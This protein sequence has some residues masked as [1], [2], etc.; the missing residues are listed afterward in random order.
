MPPALRGDIGIRFD[1]YR[2]NDRLVEGVE[3]VGRRQ[4]VDNQLTL[5]AEF[6][7]V[8]G[9]SLF[10]ELPRFANTIHF[11]EANVM[12]FDPINDGGTMVDTIALEDERTLTGAGFGGTWI[13]LSG[14]PFHEALFARRG[15]RSS[16]RF[17]A[18]YRFADR[19]SFWT[20]TDGERGGGVGANAFKLT[21]SFSTTHK[22]SQPYLRATLLRAGRQTVEV[23]DEAGELRIQ[24][25]IIRPASRVDLRT[26]TEL[27]VYRDDA[28]GSELNLDFSASFGYRSPQT[29]PSGLLLPSILDASR[30]VLVEAAEQTYLDLGF[31]LNSR[32]SEYAQLNLGAEI[33]TVSPQRL[34]H[35]YD[36]STGF[37]TVSWQLFVE[38]RFRARDPLIKN[39]FTPAE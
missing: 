20:A 12:A 11:P 24:N 28:S 32:I 6:S 5:A 31:A 16:W 8:K 15:D 21:S 27:Q 18:A 22:Q 34:E 30:S 29:I 33:G 23:R 25:A 1:G 37:G 26:G 3:E 17:D 4:I 10:V 19:T 35:L 38:A 39:A 9:A 14:A 13:G 7:F 2:Q 36:V